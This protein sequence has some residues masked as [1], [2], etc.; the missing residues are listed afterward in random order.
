MT[1]N[2]VNSYSA[3]H[4]LKI[5]KFGNWNI[6]LLAAWPDLLYTQNEGETFNKTKK[7]GRQI[8]FE[9]QQ[10]LQFEKIQI[11]KVVQAKYNL[12]RPKFP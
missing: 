9:I 12:K 3:F 6:S 10:S 8:Q 11:E 2:Q 4:L 1:P 7:L 5:S